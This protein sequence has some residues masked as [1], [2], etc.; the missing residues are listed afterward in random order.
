MS[1]TPEDRIPGLPK[2]GRRR[3][4]IPRNAHGIRDPGPVYSRDSELDGWECE[5]QLLLPGLMSLAELMELCLLARDDARE[6]D[7]LN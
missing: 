1:L 7:E 3:P 6:R 5:D 2:G 4:S